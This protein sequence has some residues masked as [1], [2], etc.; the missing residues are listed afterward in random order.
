MSPTSHP[1]ECI[2]R[3]MAAWLGADP[4]Q[5]T[6]LWDQTAPLTGY[7]LLALQ[8]AADAPEEIVGWILR[9]RS[10]YTVQPKTC[11]PVCFG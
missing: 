4:P 7:L 3:C 9:K 1:M 5:R 11:D 8:K 2:S 10:C 6:I